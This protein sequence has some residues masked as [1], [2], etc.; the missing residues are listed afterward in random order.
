MNIEHIIR[1]ALEHNIHEKTSFGWDLFWYGFQA[2]FQ[3]HSIS[4]IR[5]MINKI[6]MLNMNICLREEDKK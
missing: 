4:K 6:M 3:A 5:L 2:T 1:V